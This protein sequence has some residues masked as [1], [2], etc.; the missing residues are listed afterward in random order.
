M[1]LRAGPSQ[2]RAAERV[3]LDLMCRSRHAGGPNMAK[4]KRSSGGR[5]WGSDRDSCEQLNDQSLAHSRKPS[6]PL[7]GWFA[8]DSARQPSGDEKH[9]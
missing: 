5:A 3:G 1:N 2:T 7:P 6:S 4:V 9:V 8:T